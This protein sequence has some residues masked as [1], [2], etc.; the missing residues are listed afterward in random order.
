MEIEKV[1]KSPFKSP[2]KLVFSC[3]PYNSPVLLPGIKFI[4]RTEEIAGPTTTE[5]TINLSKEYL[6]QTIEKYNHYQIEGERVVKT[7][8]RLYIAWEVEKNGLKKLEEKDLYKT[9]YNIEE[10]EK[11]QIEEKKDD[12]LLETIERKFFI[13]MVPTV[14]IFRERQPN[15]DEGKQSKNTKP[16]KP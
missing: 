15:P 16:H 3:P 10:E 5:K 14:Y 2:F 8:Y 6:K 4:Y 12:M 11:I 9:T 7:T 13:F 1:F